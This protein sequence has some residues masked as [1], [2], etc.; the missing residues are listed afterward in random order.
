MAERRS[1]ND[2][3]V[4]EYLTQN[5][6]LARWLETLRGYCE[7]N[8][9]WLARREFILRNMESFPTVKPGVPSGS[10]DQLLSL[11]MVWANNVFL[12]CRW[13]QW[14]DW[15]RNTDFHVKVQTVRQSR[16]HRTCVSQVPSSCDDQDR[17]DVRGYSCER[18]PANENH[19]GRS[20]GQGEKGRHKR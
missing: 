4:S 10:L 1:K 8:K 12:G 17:G 6:E 13:D 16:L 18:C 20:D 14:A 7:T 2:T 15:P 19:N 3:D 9:Q 5:P 11:S